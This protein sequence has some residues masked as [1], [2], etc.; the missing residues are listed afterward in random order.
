MN[1]N[2]VTPK[3]DEVENFIKLDMLEI[4]LLLEES[5]SPTIALW[6]LYDYKSS[7]TFKKHK[8]GSANPLF[9]QSGFECL[10]LILKHCCI[11]SNGGLWLFWGRKISCGWE[12]LK[13][14]SRKLFLLNATRGE[15]VTP[16][17]PLTPVKSRRECLR[18]QSWFHLARCNFGWH[19]LC[20]VSAWFLGDINWDS[21]ELDLTSWKHSLNYLFELPLCSG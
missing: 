10:E 6:F 9:F 18:M 17:L 8:L 7:S 4:K 13:W 16:R 11:V 20:L 15:S 19:G 3:Q 2:K 14:R 21:L 5:Q 1:N 12:V